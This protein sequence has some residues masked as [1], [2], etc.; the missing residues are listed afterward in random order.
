MTGYT[1]QSA[2]DIVPTAVV[3]ATPLNNEFNAIRDSFTVATGHRHDGTTAEGHLVPLIAD[4]NGYNKVVTDSTNNR[5]GIFVNVSSAPVEQVRFSSGLIV[6][7][8]TN[9]VDI[10]SSTY[11]FKNL[12][13]SGTATLPVANIGA[14]TITATDLTVTGTID[15][16]N[17]VISNVSTPTLSTDAANKSYVDTSISN[18]INGA[19]ATIDTLNEIATAL[20]NDP[21][22][23][24]TMTNSLATKLNLSGGTMT[25]NIAMGS[26]KISGLGTPTTGSDATT[27]TYVDGILGSAT[28]AATSASAAATSASNAA[29]SEANAAAS[30]D[31][32]DD[33]Y[34]GPKSANPTL[35][36]DGNALLTGAL[37]FN[38]TANEMRVWSGS[39]WVGAFSGTVSL[40]SGVTGV[41]PV[42]NGGT[43]TNAT[44]TAGTVAYGTGTAIAY[45]SAGTSG[46]A[47]L[48]N[49][50][51]APTWGTITS[52]VSAGKAIAFAMVMGF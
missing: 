8:T 46:Q 10:G 5:I 34:L 2:A 32:F 44:P 37:Y 48:S 1:R 47:L 13:L 7:V 3:R 45:T 30:Y 31:S 18:L 15:V 14:G 28:A 49:G 19:P 16:T 50:S 4:D 22:F 42:A 43:N 39:A 12:V 9:A 23:A 36:N 29:T 33:R 24:T 6:P 52:G 11:K 27:K 17:T 41:L 25:G 21:N 35:D 40:T 51:S 38:T 20:G 26:Y